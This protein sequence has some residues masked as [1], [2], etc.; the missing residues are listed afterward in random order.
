MRFFP[1]VGVVLLSVGLG[2]CSDD[3]GSGAGGAGGGPASTAMATT[4]TTSAS[5]T[6]TS[7]AGGAGEGGAGQGG[8]GDGGGG[9]ATSGGASQVCVDCIFGEVFVQGTECFDALLACDDDLP[10]NTW[11]DCTEECF[12]MD[13][14]PECIAACGEQFPDVDPALAE[15]LFTCACDACDAV[16]GFFCP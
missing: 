7:G 9:G 11:K 16:C 2:A 10:C 3:E 6:A 13:A 15:P 4:T 14:T 8:L 1:I 5:T 12:N